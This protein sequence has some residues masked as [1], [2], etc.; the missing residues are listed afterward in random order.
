MKGCNRMSN[1]QSTQDVKKVDYMKPTCKKHEPVK[2]VQG[3]GSSKKCS[4][5]YA[6]LYY[7]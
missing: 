3:S 7:Y 4:L 1:G 5:Y 6:S 2:I